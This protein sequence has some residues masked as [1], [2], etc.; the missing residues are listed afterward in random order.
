MPFVAALSESVCNMYFTGS[1]KDNPVLRK[2]RIKFGNAIRVYF[3]GN[4]RSF[5]TSTILLTSRLV[6][7]PAEQHSIILNIDNHPL[8]VKV[9]ARMIGH[10]TETG[11]HL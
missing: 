1:E 4:P 5:A 9:I 3:T 6:D 8:N 11:F 10:Y 2:L 7:I